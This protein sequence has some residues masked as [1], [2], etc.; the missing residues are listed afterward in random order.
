MQ[1][2]ANYG[3]YNCYGAY[4]VRKDVKADLALD[5]YVMYRGRHPLLRVF[6]RKAQG[7]FS[8]S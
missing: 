2:R 4:I 3:I 5:L 7:F 1:E 6:S 8:F